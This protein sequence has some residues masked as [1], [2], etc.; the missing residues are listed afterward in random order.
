ML[1]GYFEFVDVGHPVGWFHMAIVIEG[2]RDGQ[3]FTLYYNGKMQVISTVLVE[4]P[5]SRPS[6]GQAVIGKPSCI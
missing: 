5:I 6:R 2:P 4:E 3:G 1:G